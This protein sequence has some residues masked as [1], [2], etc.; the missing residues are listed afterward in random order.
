MAADHLLVAGVARRR[1]TIPDSGRFPNMTAM[2]L[3]GTS[4]PI[5]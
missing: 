4:E 5:C 2:K 3:G 1:E